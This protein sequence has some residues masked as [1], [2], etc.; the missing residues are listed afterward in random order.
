[1]QEIAHLVAEI[2]FLKF[3]VARNASTLQTNGTVDDMKLCN[4]F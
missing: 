3:F 4:L 1:M 2:S